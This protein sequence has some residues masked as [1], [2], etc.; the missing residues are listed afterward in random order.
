MT[1]RRT[2]RRPGRFLVAFCSLAVL[3]AGTAAAQTTSPEKPFQPS[4]ASTTFVPTSVPTS[5]PD[6]VAG[7]VK[8]FR[9]IPSWT[10]LAIFAAAGIGAALERPSDLTVSRAMS[11]SP[12][13]GSFFRV[14]ETVGGARTQLAGALATYAIGQI[15]GQRKVAMIGADLIQSQ[16]LAQTMTAAIK[17]SVGRTRPDGTQYS[18]P[19]GH[20]SVMF[21]TATVLQRD[22]G[23]K[24]GIPAYGLATYVAASRIQ[25][26]R[27]FL[28]DVTFG[29]A[30]GI[31]AGRSVTVGQGNAKFA[32]APTA[33]HGG[34]GISF[35]WLG[36]NK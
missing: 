15:S 14:G 3:T 35:T 34:G 23:W 22:L 27:H 7:A 12:S 18:F 5:V 30:I 17:M 8:D 32:V 28:S 16:I 31:V 26:K 33:A 29:A 25:D 11:G 13:L 10:N 2:H 4:I 19:S 21:A 20:S 9:H 24:V 1:D 6:V 36:S